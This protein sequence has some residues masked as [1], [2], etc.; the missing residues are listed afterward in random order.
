MKRPL[1]M[2]SLF[3]VCLSVYSQEKKPALEDLVRLALERN[4]K[5]KSMT[6]AVEAER[7]RIGPQ[8]ALP[9]PVLSFGVSNVGLSRWT[10]GT[11][12]MSGVSLNLSQ[13][14][15][16]PGKLRLKSE[17]AA[18]QARQSEEDLVAVKLAVVR[19]V[20]TLYARLFYYHR[21]RE[22]LLEKRDILNDALRIAESKYAVGQGAQPDVLKAQVELSSNE[23]MILTMSGM[24]RAVAAG[25]NSALDYPPENA[26]GPPEEIALSSLP[27]DFDRV[28]EAAAENS[29]TL[30]R[31]AIA[32]EERKLGVALARKEFLP[33]FMI[34]VG[35]VFRGILPDMYEAMVG[36]EIPVFYAK[37]QAPLLEE[38]IARQ[39]SSRE[40]L[41]SMKN[42]LNAM[43][44]ESFLTAKT[45]ENV[46]TLY[47]DKIIPQASLS[48]ESSLANY[49]VNKVDF[50]MLLSDINTLVG[51]RMEY[52]RNLTALWEAGARIEE[53]TGLDIV[54]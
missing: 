52:Y 21:A 15:P 2:G 22:L 12:E 33:N 17:M 53:L 23:E 30:K 9:D 36:I 8:G 34:Q 4:P 26:L 37:K 24:I 18:Q 35:K 20:K 19:E 1:I 5:I 27:V 46:I 49:Q 11:E 31:A 10:V 14:F 44:S 54:K 7:Y 16:F 29:P 13:A 41:S 28:K 40:D 50:L 51:T 32:L 25:L 3:L 6:N 45:A 43:L 48:L 38:S 39:N 42:D 47:K